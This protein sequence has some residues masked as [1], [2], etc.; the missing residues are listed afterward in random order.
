[1]ELTTFSKHEHFTYALRNLSHREEF[2]LKTMIGM[3]KARTQHNWVLDDQN[4]DMVIAGS[5]EN[6]S[7]LMTN[8][9]NSQKVIFLSSLQDFGYA[10]D[11][12]T[13]TQ[14]SRFSIEKIQIEL[15]SAGQYLQTN[16]KPSLDSSTPTEA[17][18]TY[19]LKRW[20]S[21]SVLTSAAHFKIS[22][23]LLGPSITLNEIIKK[24]GLG[25]VFCENFIHELNSFGFLTEKV[26]EVVVPAKSRAEY[27]QM[28]DIPSSASPLIS[29]FAKIRNKLTLSILRVR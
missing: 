19:H 13:H 8:Q 25:A 11:E 16:K 29:I 24:T 5:L 10:R 3:I 6:G 7:H 23:I 26:S 14:N 15:N 1:M 28:H 4:P 18:K 20:P 27:I 12:D 22:T 9:N 21:Q 2:L 17:S